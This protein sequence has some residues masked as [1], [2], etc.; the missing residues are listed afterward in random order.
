MQETSPQ[1]LA[2]PTNKIEKVPLQATIRQ[3]FDCRFSAQLTHLILGNKITRVT[4]C[5]PYQQK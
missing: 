4:E 1:K 5:N 2:A 3:F